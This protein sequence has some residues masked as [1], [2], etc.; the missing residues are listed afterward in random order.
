MSRP[1]NIPDDLY[2]YYR[3][4]FQAGTVTIGSPCGVNCFFC[5]EKW[6][7]PGLI[8]SIERY[9]TFEEVC[10]FAEAYLPK[11]LWI[12]DWNRRI[13][14]GEFF[15]HPRSADILHYL[16]STQ[17]LF[18]GTLITTNGMDL[19]TDHLQIIKQVGA[20]VCLSLPAYDTDV[21][22]RIMGGPTEKHE[23]AV[24]AA[25][26]LDSLG[27][28]Y[29]V[30]IVPTRD[31]LD[32]GDMQRLVEH[33]TAARP[34]DITVYRPGYTKYTPPQFSERLSITHDE[35]FRFVARM[36]AE[37]GVN[38]H[39]AFPAGESMRGELAFMFS[40]WPPHFGGKTKLFLCSQP[41]K[42]A[43]K[44]C[45]RDIEMRDYHVRA[46]TS[47]LFGGNIDCAGLLTIDDYIRAIDEFLAGHAKPELLVMPWASFP[48]DRQDVSGNSVHA[49]REKYGVKVALC[50]PEWLTRNHNVLNRYR[51]ESRDPLPI[52]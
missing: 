18:D 24:C 29:G 17:K 45:L 19:T 31:A 36:Q 3:Y 49:I 21:R 50:K 14:S 28:P 10:H 8:K 20:V 5:S 13:A 48:I 38:I 47:G 7:P 26:E 51:H 34:Q 30:G 32:G 39:Y 11:A 42:D 44:S 22:Q 35:L 16:A 41:V 43:L 40:Q 46:V 27:I 4:E 52:Q 15:C 2:E 9:L 33:L 12:G 1:P 25:S 6:N 23:T 37:H